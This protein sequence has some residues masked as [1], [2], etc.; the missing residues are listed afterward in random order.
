MVMTFRRQMLKSISQIWE[1]EARVV[2]AAV[3]FYRWFGATG[4]IRALTSGCSIF[5][6]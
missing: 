3:P 5:A 2:F 4:G 6:N 1:S